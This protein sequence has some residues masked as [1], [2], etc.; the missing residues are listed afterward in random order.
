MTRIEYVGSVFPDAR[1]VVPVRHPV[2]H[3]AS[4]V[5][6][7][8]LFCEYSSRDRRVPHYLSAAG[9]FEFGP[10]RVPISVGGSAER[11][12]AAWQAGDEHLGYAI[13]W[14]AVY[15]YISD[16]LER[17]PTLA[18]RLLVV[19]Y[20][21]LCTEPRPEM[22]RVLKHLDLEHKGS[23]ILDALDHIER[24]KRQPSGD[25]LKAETVWTA[26]DGIAA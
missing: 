18:K 26:T 12:L 7:H 3:V 21:D 15:G 8:E 16:L 25:D 23:A 13:Q 24:S 6:Q 1:F 11:T 19:R 22:A 10:Q 5:R 2:T 20:E 4:L 17:S 14:A 9:H